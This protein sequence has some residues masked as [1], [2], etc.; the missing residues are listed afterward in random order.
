MPKLINLINKTFGRLVVMKRVLNNRQNQS[1]WLCL[2]DCGKEKIIVGNDLRK[3]HTKSCGC[4]RKEIITKIM[5]KHG[6]NRRGKTTKIY[7]I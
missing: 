2:C 3:G 4:L 1:M 5:T 7:Y 6:H